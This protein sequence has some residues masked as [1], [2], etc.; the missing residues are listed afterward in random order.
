MAAEAMDAYGTLLQRGS[1]SGT[2]YESVAN[3]TSVSGPAI[4]RETLETTVHRAPGTP[5]F[6]WRTFIGGLKDAGEI[7]LDVNYTAEGHN[8]LYEDF[9]DGAPRPYRMVLPDPERTTWE[10][11]LILTGFECEF[12][13]DDKASGTLSFKVSGKPHIGTM[14]PEPDQG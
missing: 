6:G 3:V 9:E 12:P 14:E 11:N 2:A 10:F 8:A 4:E 5:D 7:S 1:D 13:Y